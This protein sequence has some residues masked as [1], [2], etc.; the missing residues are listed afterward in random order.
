MATSSALTLGSS[1]SLNNNI[2]SEVAPTWYLC[3]DNYNL[4]GISAEKNAQVVPVSSQHQETKA[5]FIEAY[6]QNNRLDHLT[7]IM[8]FHPQYLACFL[9]TQNKLLRADGPLP[10]SHRHYIAIIAAARHQCTYL[11]HLHTA[12][13]LQADGDRTWLDRLENVPVKLRK[14]QE[15]NRLLAHRPWMVTSDTIKRLCHGSN[16]W[17]L[18]ELTHAIVLLA[19]FHSLCSAIFGCGINF[20]L[21]DSAGRLL[22]SDEESSSDGEAD[23][24]NC[25]Q[26]A[27]DSLL[28]RLRTLKDEAEEYSEEEGK[29][30]FETIESQ[31]NEY[32]ATAETGK[33]GSAGGSP[34]V[35]DR[36]LRSSMNH[37]VEKTDFVYADFN[38]FK[39][40]TPTFRA[41]DY[42]WESNGYSMANRLYPDMGDLLDEKFRTAQQLTYFTIGEKYTN[43]NTQDFRTGIW[44]Y[45]HCIM[46]IRHDDYDY[47]RVNSL[48]DMGFKSF[49][50]L[51]TCYP[52]RVSKKH[53]EGIMKGFTYSEKIHVSIILLEARMQSELLYALRA[54]T[55]YFR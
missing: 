45:I 51:M 33:A 20:E 26:A 35:P 19:H 12:E 21:D 22:H 47:G 24:L 32:S 1:D 37:L 31:A 17:S 27:V 3:K 49:I 7:Q 13:F 28:L 44:N 23:S 46:G 6:R 8:G 42:N 10:Y 50:K 5:L 40:S 53:F 2:C 15:I 9:R 36:C 39:E 11:V 4:N 52:E 43:V 48:L 41:S 25:E 54:V 18:S 38:K 14:L 55:Q 30:R 16:S 29:R 34:R